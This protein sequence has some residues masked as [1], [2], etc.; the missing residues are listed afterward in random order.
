MNIYLLAFLTSIGI[1]LLM[2]VPAFRYKTDK[3]TDISYAVTF[4][5]VAGIGF[6]ASNKSQ[7]H[8]LLLCMVLLWAV[9][10]GGFLLYRVWKKGRDTRFDEMRNSFWLFL[11]FWVLQGLSVF[12]VMLAAITGF[13]QTS[14]TVNIISRVGIFIFIA[15]LLIEATADM[16]KYRFSSD[17][18]NKGKWIDEG[19]WRASRH[20]NYLGEMM[21]WIGVYI[22]VTQSLSSTLQVFIAVLSPLYIICLLLFASG[23]PILEKSAEARWG[24]QKAF[25]EYKTQVPVLIPTLKSLLRIRQ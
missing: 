12:V 18:K 6:A 7:L 16:Q 20:P 8:L 11:R 1:N 15:G 19:I 3:L 14:T 9:R 4:A 2:F 13:N 10:L 23:V 22:T 25:K 24:K 5:V 17:P 21:V